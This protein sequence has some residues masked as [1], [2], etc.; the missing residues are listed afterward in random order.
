M[1]TTYNPT[2]FQCIVNVEKN[3]KEDTPELISGSQL[4][5]SSIHSFITEEKE[6]EEDGGVSAHV[7]PYKFAQALARVFVIIIAVDNLQKLGTKNVTT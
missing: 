3:L 1:H 2:A 6:D 4:F 7:T 5:N